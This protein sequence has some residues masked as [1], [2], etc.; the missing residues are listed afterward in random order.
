[1][2]SS[3]LRSGEGGSRIQGTPF[4]F[5]FG[6]LRSWV[7]GGF[8]SL[9]EKVYSSAL[10]SRVFSRGEPPDR[11][12]LGV[13]ALVSLVVPHSLQQPSWLFLFLDLSHFSVLECLPFKHKQRLTQHRRVVTWLSMSLFWRWMPVG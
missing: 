2:T 4:P 10:E 5:H 11:G 13:C 7:G 12:G 8:A 3:L 6:V 1:M 9:T